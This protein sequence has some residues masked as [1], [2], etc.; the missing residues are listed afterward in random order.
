M[1][2]FVYLVVDRQIIDKNKC[3]GYLRF[4]I[5]QTNVYPAFRKHEQN[6][7]SFFGIVMSGYLMNWVTLY[8]FCNKL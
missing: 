1:R 8:L 3:I 6:V 7:F 4:H 5:D 2:L